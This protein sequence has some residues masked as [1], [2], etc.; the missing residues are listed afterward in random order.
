MKLDDRVMRQGEICG[1]HQ[2]HTGGDVPTQT[3]PESGPHHNSCRKTPINAL[4]NHARRSPSNFFAVSSSS[5]RVT[6]LR[7][8]LRLQVHLLHNEDGR[9]LTGGGSPGSQVA[10]KL[11]E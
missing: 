5:R 7:A 8:H 10:M 9:G 2:V 11:I 4:G 6:Q 1:L 3:D